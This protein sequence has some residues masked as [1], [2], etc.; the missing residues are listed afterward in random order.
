MEPPEFD[1]HADLLLTFDTDMV[2]H[3]NDLLDTLER[4]N[5]ILFNATL[6]SLGSDH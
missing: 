4:G 6:K 1:N 5:E 3:M 2:D